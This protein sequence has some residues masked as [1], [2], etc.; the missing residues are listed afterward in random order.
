M[1]LNDER[2]QSHGRQ[3]ALDKFEAG[4]DLGPVEDRSEYEQRINSLPAE[5]KELTQESARLADLCQYFSQ[6][7]MDVPPGVLERVGRLP[8]LM[9]A[10]RI[11]ATKGINQTLM[12]YLNDVGQDPGIRQ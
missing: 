7:S 9:I 5:Q 1:A 8:S 12:E 11:R 6:Q 3:G 2:G 4:G 10:E